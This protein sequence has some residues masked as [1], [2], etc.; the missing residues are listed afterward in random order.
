MYV[1][2]TDPERTWNII[3]KGVYSLRGNQELI[4]KPK[5]QGKKKSGF[6]MNPHNLHI[7]LKMVAE[8][9]NSNLKDRMLGLEKQFMEIPVNKLLH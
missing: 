3:R 5:L 2:A 8:Q 7:D 1:N 9:D 6:Q 4:R